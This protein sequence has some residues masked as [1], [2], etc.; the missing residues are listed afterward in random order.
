MPYRLGAGT[1][2]ATPT[3]PGTY[4]TRYLPT[5]FREGGADHALLGH[6]SVETTARYPLP[7]LPIEVA[8]LIG[9]ALGR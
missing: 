5:R 6:T 2:R 1:G 7:C 3:P 4:A 9:R 8:D